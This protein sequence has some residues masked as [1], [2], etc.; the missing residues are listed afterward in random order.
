M[1]HEKK[2][3]RDARDRKE[4]FTHC[5][6]RDAAPVPPRELC[7]I[8]ADRRDIFDALAFPDTVCKIRSM[9]EEP[10]RLE[11]VQRRWVQLVTEQ[12]GMWRVIKQ[13]RIFAVP[14]E[15]EDPWHHACGDWERNEWKDR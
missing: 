3:A 14:V 11:Q 15:P 8:G 6:E 4:R 1:N 13:A 12:D 5:G 2:Y 9:I 10:A 7:Q